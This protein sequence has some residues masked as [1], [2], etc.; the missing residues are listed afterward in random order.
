MRNSS[1]ST[2]T[3]LRWLSCVIIL[4]MPSVSRA[5]WTI[6]SEQADAPKDVAGAIRE[7]LDHT[8]L[9]VKDGDATIAEFWLRSELPSSADADQIKNGVSW[10]EIPETTILGVVRL[11]KAFVDY[12]KQEIPAG[13]Y[14]LRLAMQPDTGDHKDTA[15][16]GEF[17]LLSPAGKDRLPETIEAK[18]LVKLSRTTTGSDH[19]AVMLIFPA[20]KA[21]AEPKLVDKGNGVQV[22]ELMRTVNANGTFSKLGFAITVGGVSKSR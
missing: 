22:V 16:H 4:V 15:P 12:R 1:S 19:P 10:K 17:A 6:T 20:K 2:I 9:T 3:R 8:C 14:T 13:L 18:D 11:P 5:A 21:V 7:L